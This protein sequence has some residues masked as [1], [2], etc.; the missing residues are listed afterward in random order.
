MSFSMV[1]SMF[2]T[3]SQLWG[4]LLDL[5]TTRTST[6]QV[7]YQL[8]LS[9]NLWDLEEV[10]LVILGRRRLS[11]NLRRMKRSVL[12]IVSRSLRSKRSIKN[13]GN[14]LLTFRKSSKLFQFLKRKWAKFWNLSATSRCKG[15]CMGTINFLLGSRRN[16]YRYW[17]LVRK[18]LKRRETLHSCRG[19]ISTNYS[20]RK[21]W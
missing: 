20:S 16:R 1:S 10:A 19:P 6:K 12:R 4:K 15:A 13:Q 18:W 17:T 9:R 7:I 11:T 21:L 2:L 8:C 3:S 14:N 5:S